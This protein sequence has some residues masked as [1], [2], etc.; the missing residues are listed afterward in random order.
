MPDAYFRSPEFCG[1][2]PFSARWFQTPGGHWMHY[3]DEGAGPPLVLLHGNP[4]WSFYYRAVIRELRGTHRVV[5]P[6]H[7]GC[8]RSDAPPPS[9]YGYRLADRIGDLEALLARLG[10]TEGL[11]LMVH[12]WGG[13]IGLGYAVRHP[14]RI[15]S[16]VITNTA[17]FFPPGR[18]TAPLRLRLI[19]DFPFFAGPAVL[20]LNLFAGPALVM[21]PRKRLS[22]A[23]RRG[24]IAPYSSPRR[25]LATLRFVQ[26]IPLGAGD[27]SYEIVRFTDDHLGRLAHLPVRIIWGRHDFVFTPRYFAE[28]RR[29]F[30]DAEAMLLDTAGH[31][32]LE[33][34]P[35]IV[36]RAVKDFL[37]K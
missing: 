27:P 17:G 34:E 3:I 25:R 12:D 15:R 14:G 5:A 37:K 23:A 28:F 26:D 1:E 16:L 35:E 29:R 10:L 8:G 7:L 30:P 31:Y 13:M 32:L 36:T 24:L 11:N 18:S 21:A 33:D 9:A 2:Y 6:D 4:T 22:P 20:G 19:R